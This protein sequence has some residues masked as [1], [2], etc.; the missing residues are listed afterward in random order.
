MYRVSGGILCCR[1]VLDPAGQADWSRSSVPGH[2]RD[3]R[4]YRPRRFA[5]AGRCLV[6]SEARPGKGPRP[7]L[8][9][10]SETVDPAT[11]RVSA[12][13]PSR[14]HRLVARQTHE[15]CGVDLQRIDSVVNGAGSSFPSPSDVRGLARRWRRGRHRTGP[16]HPSDVKATSQRRPALIVVSGF[17]KA[18]RMP[19]VELAASTT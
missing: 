15:H 17:G 18:R 11:E 10:P 12:A 8:H 19:K 3:R 14:P 4:L 16:A 9:R 2:L 1:L 13:A 5:D 6:S 7:H